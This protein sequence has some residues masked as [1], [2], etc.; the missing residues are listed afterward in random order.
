[1]EARTILYRATRELLINVAKHAKTDTATVEV[2]RM[3]DDLEIPPA[4]PRLHE[5]F[6]RFAAYAR[7]Q[8]ALIDARIAHLK[9]E[10]ARIGNLAFAY[11]QAGS[12]KAAKGDDPETYCGQCFHCNIGQTHLCPS[13][14]LIGRDQNGG[15]ALSRRRNVLIVLCFL[16][17]TNRV[18]FCSSS[19]STT[20]RA[21]STRCATCGFSRSAS[22]CRARSRFR[23][24]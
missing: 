12:P 3:D 7:A 17:S 23:R 19:L 5:W 10:Q 9:A 6:D 2:E 21:Q 24:S 20:R 14:T 16:V 8:V 1:M 4:P 18:H 15:F 22:T 11:D 13:G